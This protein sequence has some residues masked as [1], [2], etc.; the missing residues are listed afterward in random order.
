MNLE[1]SFP[2]QR[3]L[4]RNVLLPAF[5]TGLK[6][7]KTFHY[8]RDLERSQWLSRRELE[9]LQ[10]TAL[11]KLV[12]HAFRHCPYYREVWHRLGVEPGKLQTP[13]DFQRWPVIDRDTIREHRLRMRAQVAGMRLFQK[14]TGG[15]SGVPLQFD[16]DWDSH[17]R[18]TAAW[19]RGYDWAGAG[20]GTKQLYL[21][22]VPLG[23]QPRWQRW[24]DQFYN[25]LNRRLLLNSFQLNE[26]RV[27]QFVKQLNRYRPDAIVAY[28]NP[29]YAFARSLRERGLRP[30]SPRTIVVGAEKL[31][32]FQRELIEDV[33]AAPVFETYGS[34]EFMLMGAECDRHEGLHLTMENLLIE[35]LAEDGRPTPDGAEGMVVVTD[36]YNYGMPFVRYANGDRAVAG[37]GRCSCGRGLPLLRKVVG[38]RL[39]MLHTPDGRQIPGEF[40]PHLLKDFPAVRRFQ[41]VQEE[42]DRVQLRVVLRGAW[43]AANRAALDG[44][45]QSVLGPT[46]RY[47]FLPVDD[48]PLTAAGK[49][50]VVVNHW[51]ER[52]AG[53]AGLKTQP[54]TR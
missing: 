22:G 3:F 47:D 35:V 30:Y 25:C 9:R 26:E 6:R 12:A 13:G 36:L 32:G 50:R 27:P 38:R 23:N 1:V 51:A 8:L 10:F 4:F 53:S 20:P 33:F 15:S 40:F 49:L 14:T 46:M 31:H 5:E 29:L 45:I 19:H 39:D 44:E 54:A 18:R 42:A 7:R 21:W 24:K 34:R 16:L 48:I 52:G 41:V 17:D 11:Q 43:T 37:W 2:M 28:T